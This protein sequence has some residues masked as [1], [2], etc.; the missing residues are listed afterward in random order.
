VSKLEQEARTRARRQNWSRVTRGEA[1]ELQETT[2]LSTNKQR[3]DNC[4]TRNKIMS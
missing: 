1:A 3:E 4:V 2:I